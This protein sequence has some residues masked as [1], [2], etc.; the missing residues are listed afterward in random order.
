MSSFD[1]IFR[2]DGRS[3]CGLGA[4]LLLFVLLAA[5]PNAASA[6]EVSIFDFPPSDGCKGAESPPIT[7]GVANRYVLLLFFEVS[8]R[9]AVDKVFGTVPPTNQ[10]PQGQMDGCW[11]DPKD[12]YL[13][14]VQGG[15]PTDCTKDHLKEE[16]AAD[17]LKPGRQHSA[18][19][20]GDPLTMLDKNYVWGLFFADPAGAENPPRDQSTNFVV[21]QIFVADSLQAGRVL[22]NLYS[23]NNSK[24]LFV[25]GGAYVG[26]L[27]IGYK[28]AAANPAAADP[29]RKK[30]P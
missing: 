30:K 5:K 13:L 3:L 22:N 28:P 15:C 4:M 10:N 12:Q 23:A 2:A 21:W 8:E 19:P 18:E 16:K 9:T 7:A 27:L 11:R 25:R 6:I 29:V 24:S 20:V 14:R 26:H 1:R 17:N